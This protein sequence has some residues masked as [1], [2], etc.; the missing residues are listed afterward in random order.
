MIIFDQADVQASGQYLL[1]CLRID[2]T[3]AGGDVA[4]PF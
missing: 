1:Y 4:L 3:A 2:M